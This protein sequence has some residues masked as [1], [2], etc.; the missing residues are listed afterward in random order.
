MKYC[1]E[2]LSLFCFVHHVATSAH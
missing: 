1:I 2:I